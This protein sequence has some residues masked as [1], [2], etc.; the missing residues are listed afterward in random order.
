MGCKQ[1]ISRP[2]AQPACCIKLSATLKRFSWSS[3]QRRHERT[4]KPPARPQTYC[5]R[6]GRNLPTRAPRC[7]DTPGCHLTVGGSRWAGRGW[8]RARWSS[9]GY[10]HC[11]AGASRSASRTGCWRGAPARGWWSRSPSGW[12]RPAAPDPGGRRLPPLGDG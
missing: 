7:C 5:R 12:N 1:C 10:R 4:V 9:A 8:Q 11:W 2:L 6:R 3:G